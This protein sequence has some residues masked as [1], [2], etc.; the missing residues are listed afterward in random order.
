MGACACGCGE[1]TKTNY[2]KGHNGRRPLTERFW[3]KVRPAGVD[4]CWEWAGSL[5][6]GYGQIN[7]G[8]RMLKAHRVAWELLRGP[9]PEG[10]TIDH[11]CYNPP[12]VN[13]WHMDPVT[14]EENS[15]RVRAN[16]FKG[17][18]ACK[19]G[20]AYTPENTRL[21]EWGG[22]SCRQ[23]DRMHARKSKTKNIALRPAVAN[24]DP[25]AELLG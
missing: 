20:H 24:H 15:R 25:L 10:L 7:S 6:R 13:P 1:E 12:C 21:R 19:R 16:Q 3:E 23:C 14:I 22:R 4:E 5:S 9:I 11:L 8:G 18:E 2:V 17:Q